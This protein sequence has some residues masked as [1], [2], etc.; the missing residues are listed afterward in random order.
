MAPLKTADTPTPLARRRV[1]SVFVVV[2]K[3]RVNTRRFHQIRPATGL[4]DRLSSNPFIVLG[5]L[6]QWSISKEPEILSTVLVTPGLIPWKL[7]CQYI[8]LT[9]I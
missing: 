6:L 4:D 2:Y 3:R 5:T 7:F 8:M 9:V 1:P